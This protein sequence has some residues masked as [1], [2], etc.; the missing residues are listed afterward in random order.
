MIPRVE[1]VA[2]SLL[3]FVVVERREVIRIA[4]LPPRFLRSMDDGEVPVVWIVKVAEMVD[5]YH[6]LV[7]RSRSGGVRRVKQTGDVR[8]A[9][10][11]GVLMISE[12]RVFERNGQKHDL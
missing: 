2:F 11:W 4:G 10:G 1:F 3:I 12:H 5:I 7:G 6:S 8:S 9:G